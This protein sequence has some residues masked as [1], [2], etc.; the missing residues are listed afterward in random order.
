MGNETKARL[1][2]EAEDT[3]LGS[4]LAGAALSRIAWNIG[5]KSCGE[6]AIA[7]STCEIAALCRM[8]SVSSCRKS[9]RE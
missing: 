6:L 3:H 5:S 7:R 1:L 4:A 2:D 9:E 8:T